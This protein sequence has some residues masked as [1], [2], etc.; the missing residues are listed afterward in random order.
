[1]AE[2]EIP[3]L[4]DTPETA[5][6]E[7]GDD[8]DAA[9]TEGGVQGPVLDVDM[10]IRRLLG[11]KDKPGKQVLCSCMQDAVCNNKITFK[12]SVIIPPYCSSLF[13]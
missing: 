2:Q 4:Q 1:M 9:P 12:K 8:G 6:P 13:N 11:Y 5:E 3:L 7:G 10:I